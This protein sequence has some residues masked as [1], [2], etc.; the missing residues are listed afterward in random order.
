MDS[1]APKTGLLPGVGGFMAGWI[2][3]TS[4]SRLCGRPGTGAHLVEVGVWQGRSLCY[5]AEAV[6]ACGKRFQK[7]G[8]DPF[9]NY[10]GG[11]TG[12]LPDLRP[13]VTAHPW[14]DVVS[15]NSRREGMLDYVHLIQAR[16]PV[17][18][19]LY[20]D[21]SLDYGWIDGAHDRDS[22]E[23]DCRAWWPKV[24]TGGTLAGHDFDQGGVRQGVAGAVPRGRS[25]VVSKPGDSPW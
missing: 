13:L 19:G 24:R 1:S 4:T 22:V 16:S 25:F 11:K 14:L 12:Y 17:A 5:S 2:M 18:A 3:R 15:A 8:I 9:R 6:P 10:P 21:G 23:A 7:D 20:R